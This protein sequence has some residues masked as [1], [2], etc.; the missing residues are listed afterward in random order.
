MKISLEFIVY[1]LKFCLLPLAYCPYSVVRRPSSIVLRTSSTLSWFLVLG[2]RIYSVVRRPSSVVHLSCVLCL[3]SC[4][5]LTSCHNDYTPKPKAYP[6]VILPE[7]KYELYEAPGCPFKFE[8]PV[9]AN[10]SRDSIYFGKRIK[11]DQCWMDVNFPMVNGTINLTY[12]DINDT[13]KLERLVEDAHKLSFKHT[14]KADYI[15]EIRIQNDHGI[16]GILYD[17]GGDAASNVQFFLTDSTRHFI[18]GA[19]YFN[20]PPNTDSM[21]PVVA[22]VK[23]DMKRMLKTFEWK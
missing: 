10:V 6:R 22:F 12:K 3:M 9:Y 2:S 18:R 17:V 15:D 4:V 1:S 20:N 7:R 8:K 16:G 23:E 5:L 14:T 13:M 21:A 19:L 11:N